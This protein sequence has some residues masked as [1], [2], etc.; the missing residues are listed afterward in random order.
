MISTKSVK[1]LLAKPRMSAFSTS[2][3]KVRSTAASGSQVYESS[4]AVQEY[5]LFHYGKPKDHFHFQNG[6]LDALNFPAR[7]AD[8]CHA[9]VNGR[10]EK[11]RALDIGCAVGGSSFALAKHYDE[12]VGVDFSQHFIDAANDMKDKGKREFETLVRGNVYKT[13]ETNLDP[14]IDR[15]RVTFMQGDACNLSPSL[16]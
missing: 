4:R 14:T 11:T 5:L 6:P 8:I 10:S 13:C 3:A 12:V 15:N 2:T 1:I 7:S 9:W 16:G